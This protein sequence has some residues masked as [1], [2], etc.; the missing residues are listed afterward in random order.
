RRDEDRDQREQ[1]DERRQAVWRAGR[2]AHAGSAAAAPGKSNPRLRLG[3]GRRRL[4]VEEVELDVVVARVHGLERIY[5]LIRLAKEMS[6]RG[7]KSA[8][9]PRRLSETTSFSTATDRCARSG[10]AGWV[11]SGSRATSAADSTSR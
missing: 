11:T 10:R 6:W 8:E 4:V 1:S 3:L 5:R 9:C 7:R 2:P